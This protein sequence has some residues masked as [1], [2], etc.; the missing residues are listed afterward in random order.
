MPLNPPRAPTK[1]EIIR[2]QVSRAN[3]VTESYLYRHAPII[4]AFLAGSIVGYVCGVW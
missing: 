1:T 2:T 3:R 4:A